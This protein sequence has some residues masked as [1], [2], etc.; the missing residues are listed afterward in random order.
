MNENDARYETIGK[1]TLIDRT[2][3]ITL[4]EQKHGHVALTKSTRVDGANMV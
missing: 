4:K 1:H 3:T 2:S